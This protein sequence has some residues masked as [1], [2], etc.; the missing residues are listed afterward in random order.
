MDLT[1]RRSE[2]I[3]GKG[4]KL[5]REEYEGDVME[6]QVYYYHND[7]LGSPVA[8]TDMDGEVVWKGDYMPFGEDISPQVH[9]GNED[10]GIS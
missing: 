7:L 8:M 6:A 3:Y 1:T 10:D 4:R 5:A 2:Y 9:W